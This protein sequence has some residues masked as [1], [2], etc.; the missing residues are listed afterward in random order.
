MPR[1]KLTDDVEAIK[2]MIRVYGVEILANVIHASK[3]THSINQCRIEA[4]E[5]LA[6]AVERDW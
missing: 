4:A 6:T 1:P 3:P 2:R 5:Q